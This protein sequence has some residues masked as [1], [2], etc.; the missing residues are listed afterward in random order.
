MLFSLQAIESAIKELSFLGAV[1]E[2]DQAAAS[3]SS[4][5]S[6]TLVLTALGTRMSNFA[7]DPKL[8]RMLLASGDLV[9]RQKCTAEML[10]I[11]AIMSTDSFLLSSLVS[12]D[13]FILEGQVN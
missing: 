4:S 8:S 11:V 5:S 3:S 13:F 2:I 12:G 9:V 10:T 1:E 7:L 6:P